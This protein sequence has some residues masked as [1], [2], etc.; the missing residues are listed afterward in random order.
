MKSKEHER[1]ETV[2]LF[3]SECEKNRELEDQVT[4]L[5]QQN[6]EGNRFFVELKMF[7]EEHKNLQE[8]YEAISHEKDKLKNERN[9]LE[10]S[11]EAFRE[12]AYQQT[13]SE[14]SYRCKLDITVKEYDDLKIRFR[15]VSSRLDLSLA[16]LESRD[17]SFSSKNDELEKELLTKQ[18]ELDELAQRNLVLETDLSTVSLRE[19]K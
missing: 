5:I 4:K 10:K 19:S 7:Q 14:E 16:N 18:R 2:A 9:N 17:S 8:A 13:Q 15:D 11:L 12:K 6:H 3:E 1:Q